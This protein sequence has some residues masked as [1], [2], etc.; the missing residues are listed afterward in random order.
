M[1]YSTG[2]CKLFSHHTIASLKLTK[3]QSQSYLSQSDLDLITA[4]A[5][6]KCDEIDGVAD[7]V[8]E[9]PLQ[10]QFNIETLQCEASEAS[11][12]ACL[13]PEQIQ[14]A[15]KIYDGPKR[16]SS[17]VVVYPGFS[18]GSEKSWL[19]QE[20][21]LASA[22]SIPILQNLVFNN[23]AYNA[24]TFNW[25]T[26]VDLV[27]KRSGTLMDSISADLSSFRSTGAKMVVTQGWAD[28][29]NAAIW[30]IQHREQLQNTMHGDV[31]DWFSLFMVPGQYLV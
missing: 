20:Q 17:N 21:T 5:L 26:D 7:G 9:N 14:Q 13:T 1:E 3:S 28:A 19:S 6:K 31:D 29:Y 12:A 27:D 24:S 16:T 10:C 25:G 4:A 30:P 15:K 2:K 11:G 22:F 8:I 18:I 23:L